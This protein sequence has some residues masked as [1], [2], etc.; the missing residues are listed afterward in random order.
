[1]CRARVWPTSRIIVQVD[2]RR[3]HLHPDVLRIAA[4]CK[5]A[6]GMAL[7]SD[8]MEAAGMPDGNTTSAG[9][10]QCSLKRRGAAGGRRDRR[11][12]AGAAPRDSQHDYAGEDAAGNCDSDGDEHPGGFRR[13]EGLRPHRA[14]GHAAC[15]TLMDADGISAA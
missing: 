13:R 7:I 14:G 15:L 1:M 10:R 6:K 4:L 12:D 5:G 3:L 9:R 8:S 11:F 2:C